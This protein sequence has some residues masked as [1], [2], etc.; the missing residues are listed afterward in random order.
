MYPDPNDGRHPPYNP[1]ASAPPPAAPQVRS[2]GTNS[3]TPDPT[4][5]T[6]MHVPTTQPPMYFLTWPILHMNPFWNPDPTHPPTPIH[7]N[8]HTRTQAATGY[9]YPVQH[10]QAGAAVQVPPPQPYYS[11]GPPPPMMPGHPPPPGATHAYTVPPQQ[12]GGMPPP[13]PVVGQQPVYYAP[14]HPAQ[15]AKVQP[16]ETYAAPPSG[17]GPPQ[18]GVAGV[19]EAGQGGKPNY[20]VCCVCSERFKSPARL[21]HHRPCVH[22][23]RTSG[24]R[25]SSCSTSASSCTSRLARASK[26]CAATN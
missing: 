23:I 2:M 13:P 14:P 25:S 24:P 5:S 20:Q 10:P 3:E 26:R 16:I 21:I 4:H 11:A 6:C 22:N 12:Y 19:E 8:P 1:H 9:Y 15:P 18:Q 7:N 17:G